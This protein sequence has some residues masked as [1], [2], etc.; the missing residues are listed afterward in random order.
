MSLEPFFYSDK[1]YDLVLHNHNFDNL[2]IKKIFDKYRRDI[3]LAIRY[4][5]VPAIGL[6]KVI[7]EFEAEAMRSLKVSE[8]LFEYID[9]SDFLNHLM[10][11]IKKSKL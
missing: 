11:E 2:F 9:D 10:N 5:I 4:A 6:L 7:N 8:I 3:L 1:E